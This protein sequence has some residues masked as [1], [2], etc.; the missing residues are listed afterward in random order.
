MTENFA[1]DI[2]FDL[3]RRA[4]SGTSFS[5]EDRAR[6]EIAG[7]AANLARELAEL[8][9]LATTPE[10]QATL[11]A[12]F[13]RYR[14]AFCG[15]YLEMLQAKSR[16]M[17]TMITGGSG[18][19]VRR[20]RKLSD[21]AD[22]RTKELIE[23][24]TRA[25]AAIR[26]ALTPEL[27]PIMAGDVD[28]VPRLDAKVQR[29][30]ADLALMKAANAA[31]RK[32]AKA[33]AEAQIAALVELGIAA[34]VAARLLERDELGRIGFADYQIRNLAANLRRMKGRTEVIQQAQLTPAT[35]RQGSRARLE[36]ATAD[37]RVRLFFP[38]KPDDATRSRLKSAGFRWAPSLG[39]WSAYRNTSS[40][41]VAEREAGETT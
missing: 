7:Y 34:A 16:C 4:H 9:K 36:D 22:K 21:I 41:A 29:A 1:T 25:L 17:S 6:S 19:P 8:S 39:C 28:A 23:F 10:K 30:E 13:L 11:A 33:G 37:N 31:I 26:K 5:P 15:R 27:A 18:F 24:R 32:H 35:G 2:P 14:Q 20:Q 40:L 3:A 38:G 12:E